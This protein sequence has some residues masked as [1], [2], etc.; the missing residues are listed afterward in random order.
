MERYRVRWRWLLV[1]LVGWVLGGGA[2]VAAPS[3]GGRVAEAAQLAPL[4]QRTRVVYGAPPGVA[5]A[6]YVGLERGY[7]EELNLA[8]ELEPVHNTAA[9]APNLVN[10][11]LDLGHMAAAPGFFNAVARGLPIKAILDASH[12]APGGRSHVVMARQELYDSGQLRG[13][14]QLRGR[15]VALSSVPGGLGI[16]LDRALQRVGLTLD[17]VEQVQLPFVEQAVALANGSVDAAV[18]LEPFATQI[19]ERGIAEVIRY[20]NDDYPDHQVSFVMISTQLIERPEVTR[21]FAVAYLRAARAYER[22]RQFGEGVDEIAQILSRYNQQAPVAVA[23][24]FRNGGMTAI[25]PQ[26]RLRV[27]SIQYDLDWYRQ[28]GFVDRAI[29]L[30]EFVDP[31]Y[32]DYAVGVLGPFR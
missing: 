5:F 30:A 9:I 23:A 3:V 25:D 21:A 22:A 18:T 4:P 31:Q 2:P 29:D 13:V 17:A 20:L 6:V 28:R 15:R 8:V 24:A 10:G 12:Y 16:D 32:A 14:E 26:G 7:F 1:A 19:R 27:E 11:S